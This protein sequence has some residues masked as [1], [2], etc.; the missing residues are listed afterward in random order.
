MMLC[1]FLL[2]GQ[3]VN[4]CEK[5]LDGALPMNFLLRVRRLLGMVENLLTD[6]LRIIVV[7]VAHL[8]LSVMAII[9]KAMQTFILMPLVILPFL[10]QLPEKVPAR[11]LAVTRALLHEGLPR[12]LKGQGYHI[13]SG[14]S[15]L[16][17]FI[18]G[19]N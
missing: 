19:L 9:M 14:Q 12:Q 8:Q 5:F 4:L 2:V 13:L 17:H 15:A 6:L 3:V 10:D 11:C 1:L 18:Y 16:R 7:E